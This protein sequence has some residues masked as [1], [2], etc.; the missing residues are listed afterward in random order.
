MPAGFMI[1]NGQLLSG[2]GQNFKVVRTSRR[3][4]SMSHRSVAGIY[5][6]ALFL[7]FSSW[8]VAQTSTARISGLVTDSS[9]AVLPG[10]QIVVSNVAT[11]EA[12]S[13]TSNERG[14]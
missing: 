10:V 4:K 2:C 9:G 14:R 5:I 6:A 8:A 3:K 7:A 12:R 11:G 13:V 1:L